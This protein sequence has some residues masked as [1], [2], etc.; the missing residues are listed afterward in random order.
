MAR[1]FIFKQIKKQRYL[2]KLTNKQIL[3]YLTFFMIS[4]KK[5]KNNTPPKYMLYYC[6]ARCLDRGKQ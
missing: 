4:T 6:S 5:K 2:K 1:I 3:N